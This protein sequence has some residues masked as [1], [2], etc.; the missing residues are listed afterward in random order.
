MTPSTSNQ[1]PFNLGDLQA[2]SAYSTPARG[3][4]SRR[5]GSL[6]NSASS[7]A[8]FAQSDSDRSAVEQ[9]STPVGAVLQRGVHS[10]PAMSTPTSRQKRS[11][12]SASSTMEA[13][14]VG[15]TPKSHMGTPATP[16][17]SAEAGKKHAAAPS[18][19]TGGMGK[20]MQ[21]ATADT[22]ISVDDHLLDMVDNITKLSAR[23]WS[24]L[25]EHLRTAGV[26]KGSGDDQ[27]APAIRVDAAEGE[28]A[29]WR[30]CVSSG[31]WRG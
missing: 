14:P 9:P 28:E 25:F 30:G 6:G 22:R 18:N 19:G 7:A 29:S 24:I 5:Q 21:M 3:A 31:I 23:T 10:T 8:T 1:P 20:G 13:Q 4:R 17:T 16:A 27:D 12:S 2:A 26:D 11:G 15:G